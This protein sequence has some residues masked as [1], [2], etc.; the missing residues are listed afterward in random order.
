MLKYTFLHIPGVGYKIESCLWQ[1]GIYSWYDFFENWKKVKISSKFAQK[2]NMW[3]EESEKALKTKNILFFAEKLPR[4][5]WWRLYP[6]FKDSVAFL[7][8]ETTGLSFYYDDITLIGVYDGARVKTFIQGQNL[9]AL[10]K[11][12]RKYQILVTYNGTL[13]D[14]PFIN[15]KLGLKFIPPVHIDLRFLLRRLGFKGSLKDV[16]KLVGIN[17]EQDISQI[18]GFDATILWNRY[19]RGDDHALELLV[20]YNVADIVSLKTLLEFACERFHP[21]LLQSR[22]KYEFGYNAKIDV[23]VFK[24]E[25]SLLELRVGNS[26]PVIIDTRKNRRR[27]LTITNLLRK[28]K[29]KMKVYPKSVGIDL[30]GS[31]KRRTGWALLKGTHVQ[32]RLLRTDEEIVEATVNSNPDLISID[33]P[34]SLPK[35][36]DCTKDSCECRKFGIMREAERIL[37]SRGVYIFPS[38]IRSMQSLTERGIKLRKEFEKRGFLVIESYPG[39]AQDILKIARKKVSLEELREGLKSFG[40]IGDFVIRNN[41]HDK[42]D[43]IT[44][45]LVG[46]FYL[47]GDYEALGN[48][49]EGYLIVPKVC[50][51][52][53]ISP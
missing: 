21:S 52:G 44:A 27:T 39:A 42:L 22:L 11:E 32:T 51:N 15:Y 18:G 25:N 10:E 43:A 19:V 37:R 48:D 47:T 1:Q 35:G 9:H 14:L 40:L 53:S 36:R 3:L 33:S 38:L 45:A 16:E 41:S 31:E 30:S 28:L 7:D 4:R 50:E 20:K 8:I 49:I 13:F 34:L 5:E 2:I 24:K 29:Q 17:R 46:Y 6:E 12:I 23:T 26:K